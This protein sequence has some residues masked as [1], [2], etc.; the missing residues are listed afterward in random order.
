MT[1]LQLSRMGKIGV[2][3]PQSGLLVANRVA[4]R[5]VGFV[6]LHLIRGGNPGLQAGREADNT[7]TTGVPHLTGMPTVIR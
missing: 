5:T 6:L 4:E 7:H 3:R 1:D 2:E